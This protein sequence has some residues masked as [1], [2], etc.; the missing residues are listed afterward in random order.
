MSR[1]EHQH[2]GVGEPAQVQVPAGDQDD[3][4]VDL[5]RVGAGN[6]NALVLPAVHLDG[7]DQRVG[8]VHL[9]AGICQ[10]FHHPQRPGMADVGDV[11]LVTGADAQD[12][13]ASERPATPAHHLHDPD[14]DVPGHPLVLLHGQVDQ[15]G[16]ELQRA[17]L[18]RQ[19]QRVLRN[20]RTAWSHPRIEGLEAVGLGGGRGDDLPDVDAHLM[21]EHRHLV[22]QPDVDQPVAVLQQLGELGH[23]RAAHGYH[24]GAIAQDGSESGGSQAGALLCDAADDPRRVVDVPAG[25][26]GIDALW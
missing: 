18:P 5:R 17:R 26:A 8:I 2:P 7:W 22:H 20:A 16:I 24:Q 3:D 15:P 14:E 4:D 23:L 1:V 25:A 21:G 6:I 10:Q 9:R 13:A 12:M 19:V 11:G